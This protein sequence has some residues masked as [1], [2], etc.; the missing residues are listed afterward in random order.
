MEEKAG[1]WKAN[2][3]S[4]LIL[5]LVGIVY[6]LLMYFLDLSF[7]RV[8]GYIFMLLQFALLFYLVKSYRNNYLNGYITYGQ[9]LGSGVIICLYSAIITAV[10]TY[11]LYAVIDTGLAEKQLAFTEEMMLE[12]GI[13]QAQIDAGMVVQKKI[14]VPPIIALIS[15]FGSMFYGTVMSLLVGIF[16][17]KEGNPLIES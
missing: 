3:N 14:M 17:R 5:G 8:Q 12:R 6:S 7:N 15:I 13:P 9:A 1:V 2:L 10:F 4:G 11:I 16:V